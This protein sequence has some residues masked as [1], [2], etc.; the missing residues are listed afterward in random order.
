MR[1]TAS[2]IQHSMNMP[3]N[4]FLPWLCD[5][6]EPVLLLGGRFGVDGDHL[7]VHVLPQLGLLLGLGQLLLEVRPHADLAVHDR[8]QGEG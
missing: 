3:T 4:R 7:L 2:N 8:G 5:S 6:L 1:T